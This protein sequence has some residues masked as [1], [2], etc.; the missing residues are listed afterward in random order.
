MV[1]HLGLGLEHSLG[2]ELCSSRVVRTVGDLVLAMDTLMLRGVRA[3]LDDVWRGAPRLPPALRDPAM[4]R[5]RLD[6]LWDRVPVRWLRAARLVCHWDAARRAAEGVPSSREVEAML[7]ARLGWQLPGG[8]DHTVPLLKATVKSLTLL[9]LGALIERRRVL[10]AAFVAE[11]LGLGAAAAPQDAVDAFCADTLPRLWQLPWENS[12]KEALWRLAV[13]GVPLLGNTHIG[14]VPAACKCGMDL[15]GASPR[16]HH[17]WACPVAQAVVGAVS[18]ASGSFVSRDALWL[19]RCPDGLD[20]EVWDVVCLAALSAIE[21]GRRYL[22]AG[23]RPHGPEASL[24]QRACAASVADFWGRLSGFVAL[25]RTPDS[26]AGVPPDHPFV[27]R[28]PSGR[29][30]VN[31]P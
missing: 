12:H 3:L 6:V 23:G 11:A 28:A 4:L 18:G 21:H 7:V 16:L 27:G 22:K 17:F 5:I 31:R 14:G 8:G 19:V 10:H 1:L 25:G 26:W 13:D 29:L 24:V 30:L 2:N 20:Q 9:Q 15:T